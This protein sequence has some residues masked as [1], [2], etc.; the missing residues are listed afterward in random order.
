MSIFI[1]FM[2]FNVTS[3]GKVAF[4]DDKKAPKRP[5]S[6]P[7]NEKNLPLLWL[8]IV[9]LGLDLD[10]LRALKTV[11]FAKMLFGVRQN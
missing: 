4:V 8:K 3:W 1:S 9:P 6:G 2:S 11:F 10:F 5:V 7:S